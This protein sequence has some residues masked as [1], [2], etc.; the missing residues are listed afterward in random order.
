VTDFG[1]SARAAV[2]PTIGA[3]WAAVRF[4]DEATIA[5][6]EERDALMSLPLAALRVSSEMVAALARLGL[7]RISDILDLPR[8]PLMARFGAELLRQL[9]RAL[10]REDEPLTPLLPVA[11]YVAERNFHEPIAREEDVLATVERRGS[12]LR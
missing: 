6:G 2:A 12:N 5:A 9:D 1:F 3:A 8:A 11:P 10:G 4:Y 7:K